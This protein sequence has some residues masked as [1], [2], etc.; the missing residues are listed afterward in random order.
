MKVGVIG[1]G[2][3]GGTVGKLWA[4]AGHDVL[5]SSRHPENLTDVVSA[6]GV[7]ARAGTV[8]Q[9]TEFADVLLFS[10]Y[11]QTMDEAIAEMGA[12]E[13]KTV[14]DAINAYVRDESG[15]WEL[16]DGVSAARELAEKLPQVKLVKAYN[17]LPVATLADDHHRSDRYVLP[18]CGD[19]ADA[20][21][22]VAK[23]IE[24]S[25]F[26]PLDLGDFAEVGHQEPGGELFAKTLTL[27]EARKALRRR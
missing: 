21:A 2:A 13:D 27:D 14:I 18:Y 20:K 25:G 26:E 8:R 11:Y 6:A 24:D 1:A 16:L 5:F 22:V 15:E 7:R 19:T 23:L 9:A 10:M 12:L 17:T 3:I 4:D